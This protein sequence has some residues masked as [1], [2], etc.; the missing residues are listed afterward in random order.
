MYRAAGQV[1]RNLLLFKAE[2]AQNLR[3]MLANAGGVAAHSARRSAETGRRCRL[4][5]VAIVNEGA[6]RLMVRTSPAL[7]ANTRSTVT[8]DS[9]MAPSW[10]VG[11]TRAH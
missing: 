3:G 2:F 4:P 10:Q 1:C 5:D 6:A 7:S 9:V 11:P 8:E